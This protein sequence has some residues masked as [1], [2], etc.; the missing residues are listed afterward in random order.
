MNYEGISA[1]M[2]RGIPQVHL[3]EGLQKHDGQQRSQ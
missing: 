2:E 3:W 1:I